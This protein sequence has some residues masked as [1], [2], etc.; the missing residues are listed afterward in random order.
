MFL[1]LNVTLVSYRGLSFKMLIRW[2]RPGIYLLYNYMF[3][4]QVIVFKLILYHSLYLGFP[5]L[6]V[7]KL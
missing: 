1:V 7:L 5:K 6:I 4:V 3:H 2:R